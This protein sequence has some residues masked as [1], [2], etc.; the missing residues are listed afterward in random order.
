MIM[1]GFQE[2]NMKTKTSITLKNIRKTKTIQKSKMMKMN[3]NTKIYR[4][5]KILMNIKY[6]IWK[7][8]YKPMITIHSTRNKMRQFKKTKKILK[9]QD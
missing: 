9:F 2:W 7:K 6:H 4:V 1:T 5:K 3:I 8:K